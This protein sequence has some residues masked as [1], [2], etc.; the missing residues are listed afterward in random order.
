MLRCKLYLIFKQREKREQQRQAVDEFKMLYKE[1]RILPSMAAVNCL[2][3]SQNWLEIEAQ[4]EQFTEI[5]NAIKGS[6]N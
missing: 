2:K 3:A 6:L 4:A 5:I 1:K